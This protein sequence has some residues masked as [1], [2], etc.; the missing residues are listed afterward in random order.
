MSHV[1]KNLIY[2]L[3][4]SGKSNIRSSRLEVLCRKGVLR[5]FEKF[6]GKLLCQSL[7][8]IKLHAEVCNYFKKETLAQVFSCEF[9]EI[10][11]NTFNPIQDGGD[12][13]PT[14]FSLVT[15]ASVGINP[16][17]FLTLSFNSFATL[18]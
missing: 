8:L 14:S 16:E 17:N 10:S 11:K 2:T 18:M 1:F 3:R 5:N 4:K 7:F 13:P 12:V 9:C 15:S 6:T